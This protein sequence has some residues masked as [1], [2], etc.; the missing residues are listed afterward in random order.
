MKESF[1]RFS[2]ISGA[3]AVGFG[4]LGAHFLKERLSDEMMA[5]FETGVRYQMYHTLALMAVA[6]IHEKLKRSEERRVGK[7]CRL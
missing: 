6:L 5:A 4:A 3:I 7:E 2:G 1:L